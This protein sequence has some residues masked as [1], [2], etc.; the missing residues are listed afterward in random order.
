MDFEINY[1]DSPL[2]KLRNARNDTERFKV[3][4]GYCW[5]CGDE[6]D[7][8]LNPSFACHACYDKE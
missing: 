4:L 8:Y 7:Y 5:H 1:D 3:I 2:G 6:K